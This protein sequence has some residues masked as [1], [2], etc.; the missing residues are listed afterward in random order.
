METTTYNFSSINR[1]E[2]KKIF[3]LKQLFDVPALFTAWEEKGKSF[4]ITPFEQKVVAI[5][6]YKLARSVEVWNK[7]ELRIKFISSILE[8]VDF[9]IYDMDVHSFS[10]RTLSKKIAKVTFQG[11]VDWMVATGEV[12]PTQPFF[13]IHEYKRG[14]KGS[15]DPVGQL[16]ATMFVAQALNNEPPKP[17]LFNPQ[18]I[19]YKEMPLYGCYI[20]GRH[21]YF[22]ILKDKDYYISPSY[23][24]TKTIEL[25]EIIKLLKAQKQLIIERVMKNN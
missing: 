2:A 21:W 16:L 5:K 1:E 13:F 25:Y 4:E 24:A 12:N 10:E 3:Q 9:D 8:L 11:N 18:P 19:S 22:V 20:I 17:T 6:Q 15:G 23:D 14:L 7:K